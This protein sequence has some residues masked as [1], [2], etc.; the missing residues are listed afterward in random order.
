MAER[1]WPLFETCVRVVV[2]LLAAARGLREGARLGDPRVAVLR[3]DAAVW[4]SEGMTPWE[5]VALAGDLA[6]RRYGLR[7]R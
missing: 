6:F 3:S 5:A 1:S 2:W 4:V 7:R